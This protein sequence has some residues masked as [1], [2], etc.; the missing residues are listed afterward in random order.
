[1][2][3]GEPSRGNP[4]HPGG[5]P[6][7][8][9][10]TRHK[11]NSEG[12][13]LPASSTIDDDLH[14]SS[15]MSH[16]YSNEEDE[17]PTQRDYLCLED[18]DCVGFDL[19]HTLCRYNI[20][21][22][23]RFEYDLLAS[24]LVDKRGYDPA[25]K[26]RDYNLDHDF[27]CKGLTLDIEKGN[28]LRLGKDGFI[29][30]ACHGTRKMTDGELEKEYGRCRKKHVMA[31]YATHLQ[32]HGPL[33]MANF[34]VQVH[35]FMDYFDYPTML[36]CGRIVDVL[37]Q[38]NNHGK[39]MEVYS[40]WT[41]ILDGM[42]AMFT[43]TQFAVDQGGYFPEIKAHPERFILKRRQEF[44][45]WLKMLR[46]NGKFL[47]VITGSHVDFASH[48]ASYAL[49][50]DWMDLFDIVIFF[51]R[52]PSFFID[53]RPFWRLNGEKEV[54]S[55]TGWDELDSHH[56]YSQG[57]WHDLNEFFEYATEWEPSACLYFGDN[58]L[59]DILAPC[60]FT[61]TI[62]VVAV[63]EEL[64]AEGMVGFESNHPH[65]DDLTS[66]VWGSYFYYPEKKKGT[67]LKRAS[68]FATR[69]VSGSGVAPDLGRTESAR[70]HG[71][72]ADEMKKTVN[73]RRVSSMRYQNEK[74]PPYLPS[75]SRPGWTSVPSKSRR[76]S[77]DQTEGN[78]G[79]PSGGTTPKCQSGRA[80]PNPE[81]PDQGPVKGTA[82]INTLWGLC[83][84]EHAKMCIPDVDV[85]ADYPIDYKFPI[86]LKE[87][88]KGYTHNAQSGFFPADPIALHTLPPPDT[89]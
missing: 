57:N 3:D 44:R 38:I 78:S 69:K 41:D 71:T 47:Y 66:A 25:I 46:N 67:V 30:A 7:L 53:R 59:Q 56:Y 22:M 32:K 35:S 86:F 9:G 18:Y 39:P 21:P 75:G 52:K 60:K 28:L 88:G 80:T 14:P 6:P 37:D 26:H 50:P 15:N 8:S 83:I 51:A 54:E 61:K 10:P 40:F 89:R 72:A 23:I 24:F 84:R 64:L 48:V 63:S 17:V 20:G 45:D 43:R 76:S 62:D 65:A 36:L 34:G 12:A 70:A 87:N 82:R 16:S 1:M 27:I 13:S 73:L 85:L 4:L 33:G 74:L 79:P 5:Q 2:C 58:V 55:F 31:D 49:G 19:D 29:L 42:K 11:S 68:S 81:E 77:V